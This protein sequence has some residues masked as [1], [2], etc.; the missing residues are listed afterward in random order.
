MD[1]WRIAAILGKRKWFILLS[2]EV[3]LLL[4]WGVT[5]WVGAKWTATVQFVAPQ[6]SQLNA[7]GETAGTS[8]DGS[9]SA[10]SQ[11]I[12]YAA[13]IKSQDVLEPTL[14]EVHL[15]QIPP[16]LLK[17]LDF[18]SNGPGLYQLQV[19]D[20]DQTKAQDITNAL[21]D[22]F[23]KVYH[24]FRTQQA[25][26]TVDLLQEQLKD[27]DVRLSQSRR[28]Y[29]NYRNVHRIVGNLTS[30][31]DAAL[32][33]LRGARQKQEDTS[34]RI[35]DAQARLVRTQTELAHLVQ[36]IPT[37][38]SQFIPMNTAE[39]EQ[40]QVRLHQMNQQLT[41]LKSRYTDEMPIVR[42]SREERDRC[43][44]QLHQLQ[45]PKATGIASPANPAGSALQ[46]D[47]HALQQEIAG[48]KALAET[49]KTSVA[50]AQSDI[51]QYKGID[52][53]LGALAA[54][55]AALSEARASLALRVRNASMLKDMTESQNPLNIMGRVNEFNPP[56]NTS[57]N[58]IKLMLL[59]AL[60]ALIASS[61]VVVG[62]DTLDH[63]LRT[64]KEAEIVLPVPVLAAIPQPMGSVTYSAMARVTQ[65]YP[66]SLQSEA[67]R[68]LALHLL[69]QHADSVRS[70][71]ICSAK[72]EQ[73]STSTLSNLGITL[74]QAGKKVILVDANIRTAELHQ[75]FGLS[76]SFGYTNLLQNP[77]APS[78]DRA[79]QSTDLDNLKV[80]C[81]GPQPA[82]PWTM[83]RSQ[84]VQDLA[85]QLRDRA[86][87]VLYD[88]P[89]SILFTDALNLA[90]I[91]DAAFLCVRAFEPVTG[92][93]D[94]LVKLLQEVNVPVLGC[95]LSDVPASLV[96]GYHNYQHYYRPAANAG[97]TKAS[98]SDG[99][100]PIASP[101]PT[102]CIDVYQEDKHNRNI[103]AS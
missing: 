48:L 94:R 56:I 91:I 51:D 87:Y 29:D 70:L 67:Y 4:T 46:Q 39:V 58:K 52:G 35:A 53:P 11:T 84:N 75:V 62:L 98:E 24:R 21:A 28:Q 68:Y 32:A 66:Q 10:Q 80:V 89:S 41:E 79:L 78:L 86:D 95:V 42:K 82:N 6:N 14:R 2:V 81:S 40:A 74:A 65:L 30:D 103:S 96:E 85:M 1:Y 54:D 92:A 71:M 12:I 97:G 102:S 63:R 83:F 31:L 47:E 26:K 90:P 69:S 44:T 60:C 3:T 88:T 37:G 45:Q 19:T 23:I 8:G 64:V 36:P 25:Q 34:Q 17:T 76:N 9:Q 43:A 20:T 61:G 100:L 7:G 16:N 15:T 38:P 57:T 77:D 72:A 99:A 18:T 93:E 55:M 49:L 5:K 22:N 27:A 101:G 13:M 59:A 33:R 73:G 50:R